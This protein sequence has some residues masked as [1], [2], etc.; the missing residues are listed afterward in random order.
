MQIC[1]SWP[2]TCCF[3]HVSK[4]AVSFWWDR[5]VGACCRTCFFT[6]WKSLTSE[7]ASPE[8]C[9]LTELADLGFSWSGCSQLTVLPEVWALCPIG[10]AVTEPWLTLECWLLRR[11]EFLAP[12]IATGVVLPLGMRMVNNGYILI[13]CRAMR[14]RGVSLGV[15]SASRWMF[16]MVGAPEESVKQDSFM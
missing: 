7:D 5:K 11:E 6:L 8:N 2:G 3:Q 13:E 15:G 16:P 12:K 1:Q 9:A 10:H 4:I 14:R